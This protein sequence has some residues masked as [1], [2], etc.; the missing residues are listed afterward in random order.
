MASLN[1]AAKRASPTTRERGARSIVAASVTRRMAQAVTRYPARATT[2]K[3]PAAEI[4]LLAAA[5]IGEGLFTADAAATSNQTNTSPATPAASVTC[6]YLRRI[7]PRSSS[8][9]AR[10]LTAVTEST[11][12]RKKPF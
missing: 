12:P 2:A 7:S 9:V 8:T 4:A 10:T 6:A 5:S 1:A 3:K 11:T